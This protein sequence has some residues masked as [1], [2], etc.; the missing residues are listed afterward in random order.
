MVLTL[1]ILSHRDAIRQFWYDGG[2]RF[3]GVGQLGRFSAVGE[4]EADFPS[5]SHAVLVAQLA[6]FIG[7]AQAEAFAT[8]L[9]NTA[10]EAAEKRVRPVVT[11]GIIVSL[12]GAGLVAM[13]ASR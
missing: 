4:E 13:V 6:A 2:V 5:A 11:R 3:R 1:A 12:V 10:A 9:E 8:A 7:E